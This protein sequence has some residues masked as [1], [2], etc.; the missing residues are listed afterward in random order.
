MFQWKG[1]LYFRGRFW[2][3]RGIS[4]VPRTASGKHLDGVMGTWSYMWLCAVLSP[5][6]P[7]ALPKGT[8][9]VFLGK[10]K[11]QPHPKLGHSQRS[12]RFNVRIRTSEQQ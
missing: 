12:P 8:D 9:G 3:L 10:G 1:T 5:T 4:G 7:P 2:L 6:D 11:A